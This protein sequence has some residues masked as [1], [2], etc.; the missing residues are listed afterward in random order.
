VLDL[1]RYTPTLDPLRDSS[2]GGSDSNGATT[3][4]AKPRRCDA[5]AGR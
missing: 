2:H 1:R 5:T 3:V 4:T